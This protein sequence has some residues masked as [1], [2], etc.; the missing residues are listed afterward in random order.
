MPNAI[1]LITDSYKN[2]VNGISVF[3]N[4]FIKDYLLKS[5]KD[6]YILE[7]TTNK[8]YNYRENEKDKADIIVDEV[9]V[10][11][12]YSASDV[13]IRQ[14]KFQGL[15]I[16]LNIKLAPDYYKVIISHGWTKVRFRF[17]YFNIYYTIKNYWRAKKL[18]QILF[19]D[20]VIFLSNAI[21]NYRHLDIQYC[22]DKE[23]K[24]SFYDFSNAFIKDIQA[25]AASKP[26]VDKANYVLAI[27]NFEHVKNVWWLLYYNL[28]RKIKGKQFKPFVLLIK[29]RESIIYSIYKLLAKKV[30]IQIVNDQQLKY[31]LIR[32]CNYL[33][34]PS[35]TEYNPI[36]A[37]EAFSYKKPV[38]SVYSITSLTNNRFYHS[39]NIA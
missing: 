30:G 36:V 24:R 27:A 35:F 12:H 31:A 19:Y 4:F 15:L 29:E 9:Y 5:Q 7:A 2:T 32:K 21:D 33:L 13:L 39:L 16:S 28:I 34:I 6:I 17:N 8:F 20:E 37:L 26:D 14:S 23:I 18:E 1:L 11:A 22:I 10:N 25:N 38:I 3:S